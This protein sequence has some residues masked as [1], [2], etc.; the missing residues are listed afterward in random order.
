MIDSRILAG[1]ADGADQL[2]ETE[3]SRAV[4]TDK[5]THMWEL[6][7]QLQVKYDTGQPYDEGLSMCQRD[8]ATDEVIV[9]NCE[10]LTHW[11]MI[12]SGVQVNCRAMFHEVAELEDWTRWK[13]WSKRPGNKVD[14]KIGSAEHIREM[15]LEVIDLLHF[16]LNAAMWLGMDVEMIYTMYLEK[17]GVN[18]ERQ[19][20]E[21][22]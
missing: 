10:S 3:L 9:N 4:T 21:E 13:H 20:T 16:W 6:Q 22:Y 15:R 17:N 18:R 19:V 7:R 14:I 12:E 1:L 5:L 8:H 11:N 2:S